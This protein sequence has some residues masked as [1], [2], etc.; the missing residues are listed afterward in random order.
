MRRELQKTAPHAFRQPAKSAAT[1]HTPTRAAAEPRKPAP[2]PVRAASRAVANG[3]AMG[4]DDG[5]EEF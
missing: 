2:Q 4:G 5:W 1:T 3:A